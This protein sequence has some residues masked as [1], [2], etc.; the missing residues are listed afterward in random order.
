VSGALYESIARIARHEASARAVCAIGRVVDVF[1]SAGVGRDHAVSVELRD[2]GLTLPR[3]PIAVGVLGFAAIPAAG[4]LVLVAFS[5][6]DT[7]APVV[8]GRLYHPDEDPPEHA[9]GQLVLALPA[10]QDEPSL[11]L[12]L[13]G[14]MPSLE[15][16]IPDDDVAVAVKDRSVR[17]AVGDVSVEISGAGGGRVEIKGGGSAVTLKKDG[18]VTV[19]TPGRLKL[20]GNEVEISGSSRV[21]VKGGVV[22][23]N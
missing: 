20:E 4:E 7:Q 23:V 2:S 13:D 10:G 3:V 9:A 12:V 17:I 22:E 5:E 8:I 1:T 6:G 19:S 14:G 16:A 18:D 15:L 11:T 21:T